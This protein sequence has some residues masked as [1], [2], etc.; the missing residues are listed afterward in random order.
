MI[1]WFLA[2]GWM[3]GWLAKVGIFPFLFYFSV[4]PFN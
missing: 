1:G 4:A 2:G 3:A